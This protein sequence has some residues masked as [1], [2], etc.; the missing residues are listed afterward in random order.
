MRSIRGIAIIMIGFTASLFLAAC[1]MPVIGMLESAKRDPMVVFATVTINKT[2][3]P[4]PSQTAGTQETPITLPTD[5][6]PIPTLTFTPYPG[7]CQDVGDE[8]YE[9]KVL[10]LINAFRVEHNLNELI[11]HEKLRAAAR[12]HSHNMACLGFFNHTGR[13]GSSP[14]DRMEAHGYIFS[15]AGENI[16]AGMDQYDN[17]ETAVNSW[18]NSSGHRQILLTEGFIHIGV[19]YRYLATSPYEGYV[20]ADFGTP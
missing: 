16:Y 2:L 12:S 8:A 10:E 20:T 7:D 1:S 5:D 14:F 11:M 15:M 6:F 19:G 4:L 17:P 18:L 3:T 9:E 13:D